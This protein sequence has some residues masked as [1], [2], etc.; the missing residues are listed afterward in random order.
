M[1]KAHRERVKTDPVKKAKRQEYQKRYRLKH[2]VLSPQK[3][4]ARRTVDNAL[5]RGKLKR[6]PCVKC[7]GKAQA[8]HEDYSKPLEVMWLCPLHHAERHKEIAT[9][10]RDK[11]GVGTSPLL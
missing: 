7:G 9:L 3:E 4:R 6:K 11:L 8:H 5:A 10:S 2:R 1:W